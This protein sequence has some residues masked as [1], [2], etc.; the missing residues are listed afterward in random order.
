M[1]NRV[2]LSGGIGNQIFQY[3]AGRTIFGS[4]TII[5][6]YSLL[7]PRLLKSGLPEL[8]DLTLSENIIWECPKRFLLTKKVAEL[9]LK[10]SSIRKDNSIKRRALIGVFPL[11]KFIV[12][13]LIFKGLKVACPRGI[14]SSDVP[15]YTTK[16][17]LLIGNFHSY[18]WFLSN[19]TQF[20]HELT[21]RTGMDR[22]DSFRKLAEIEKPI[23]IHMRF[24][25]FLGIQEL[26]VI[27]PEYFRNAL[28]ACDVILLESSVWIF[29]N[30]FK[31]A[32]E[33][34]GEVQANVV[35]EID[36]DD[37]TSGQI[38]ELLKLGSSYII[39]NSTFGWWGA[40][41]ATKSPTSVS[42]PSKWYSTMITPKELIPETWW[43]ISTTFRVEE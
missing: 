32:R 24:G 1:E 4:S 36:P 38:L 10:G 22:I 27:T 30:D 23:I 13:L 41:L 26:N 11:F 8:S 31:K 25:D 29:S 20:K 39:S 14:G 37:L 19:P 33:F 3:V 17:N 12:G 6:D 2:V 34:L 16:P 18:I 28:S 5:L 35:R 40:T 7:S 15:I 9:I 43:K 21:L 42:V